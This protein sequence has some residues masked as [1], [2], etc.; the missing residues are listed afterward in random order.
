VG[1]LSP[2]PSILDGSK[3]WVHFKD[4]QTKGWDFGVSGQ[5]PIP[6]S[7]TSTNTPCLDFV[8]NTKLGNACVSR[9]LDRVN[10]SFGYL[11][12]MQSLP[13]SRWMDII[14]LLVITLESY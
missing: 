8:R 1:E 5:T 7:N 3:I 2:D 4:S 11:G 6:L 13:R 9:T 14:W 12:D 10:T